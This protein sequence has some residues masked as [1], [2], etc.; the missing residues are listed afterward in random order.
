MSLADGVSLCRSKGLTQAEITS[1]LGDL[2]VHLGT[3]IEL[4]AVLNQ[5]GQPGARPADSC[6]NH[7]KSGL[8]CW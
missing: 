1:R 5:I 3:P 2:R 6:I 8:P 4:P 7:S